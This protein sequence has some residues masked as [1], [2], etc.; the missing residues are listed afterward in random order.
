MYNMKSV[1]FLDL[2]GSIFKQKATLSE[3]I[4]EP[5]ELLPGVSERFN[6]WNWNGDQIILTTG[7]KESTRALTE[8]QLRDNGL[9]WDILIM[10]LNTLGPRI[11][12]NNLKSNS[13]EP[14]AIA[15]NLK[16][17][18]GLINVTV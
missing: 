17:N 5:I 6:F 11:L 15:I 13:D 18:E 1:I 2:D 9:Y 8:K 7:R 10:G 14:T 16:E 4:N 12:I 3:V